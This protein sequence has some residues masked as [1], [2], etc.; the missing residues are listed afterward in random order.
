MAIKKKSED[1]KAPKNFLDND[2]IKKGI[3]DLGLL[4]KKA[5][6]KYEQADDKTKKKII[7]GVAGSI[8][9]IAGAIGISKMAGKKKEK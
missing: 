6:E 2:K 7:A 4:V 5:K 9:V 1:K 8:A 3:E